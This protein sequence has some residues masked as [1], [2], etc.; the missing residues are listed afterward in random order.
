MPE[1][2]K[3]WNESKRSIGA[4]IS[5]AG[6]LSQVLP[7]PFDKVGELF[8]EQLE[9]YQNTQKNIINFRARL[10]KVAESVENYGIPPLVFIIDELDRCRPD[11]AI[12][13]LERLKHLFNV[14]GIFFILAIDREQLNSS[15]TAAYGEGIDTD[16]YLRR[17]IDVPYSLPQPSIGNFCNFLFDSFKMQRS[18]SSQESGEEEK[19]IFIEGFSSLSKT[20]GFS[21]RKIEQCF[22]IMS[23]KPRSKLRGI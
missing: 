18:F 17:F 23:K 13:L 11:Y 9:I 20:L 10:S 19:K 4:G 21:L 3:D 5:V 1:L 15:V 6:K 14:E 7:W 12:S 16:G 2:S 8:N 22:T